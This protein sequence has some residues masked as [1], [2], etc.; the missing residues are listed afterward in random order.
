MKKTDV[1][2]RVKTLKGIRTLKVDNS[3]N[4]TE[5]FCEF[6]GTTIQVFTGL[7]GIFLVSLINLA[8]IAEYFI[9]GSFFAL[10]LLTVIHSPIG[11]RSGGH[12]NPAVT[13]AFWLNGLMAGLDAICYIIA[14]FAGAVFAVWLAFVLFPWRDPSI[15][16]TIPAMEYPLLLSMLIEFVITFNLII[17]IFSFVSSNKTGR[18]TGIAAAVYIIMITVLFAAISGASMNLAR[19][20]GT[21]VLLLNFDYLLVYFTASLLGT[22]A[23]Y[24]LFFDATKGIK[25][26]CSKL[27]HKTSGPCLFKCTCEYSRLTQIE[28]QNDLFSSII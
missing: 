14:Q 2:K 23:A 22:F 24:G 11:K 28:P 10:G 18:F 27:C 9:I 6:S 5:Y 17:M 4:L 1:L 26:T 20:F 19:T 3:L 25:P 16:L 13:T 21:A 8:D 12:L 15:T 7:T